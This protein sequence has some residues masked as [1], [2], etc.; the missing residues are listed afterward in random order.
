MTDAENEAAPE[1][2]RAAQKS[3]A[4]VCPGC[5][6]EVATTWKICPECGQRL[7]PDP[8]VELTVEATPVAAKKAKATKTFGPVP[9]EVG[10]DPKTAT[11]AAS[12]TG[13]G[14]MKIKLVGAA[15]VVAVVVLF[16]GSKKP[17]APTPAAAAPTSA[18]VSAAPVATT[19]TGA[20]PTSAAPTTEAP[21]AIE[22]MLDVTVTADERALIQRQA[23]AAY[24]LWPKDKQRCEELKNINRSGSNTHTEIYFQWCGAEGAAKY[25]KCSP[26]GVNRDPSIAGCE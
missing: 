16:S 8:A 17:P 19:S 21:L 2:S 15:V 6:A 13:G 9:L 23:Q 10:V 22:S 18:L 25:F 12:A 20:A 11:A 7:L 4:P 1:F 5:K 26:N 24:T 14:S 3:E